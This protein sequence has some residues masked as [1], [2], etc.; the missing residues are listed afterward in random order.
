MP[1]TVTDCGPLTTD[2][3]CADMVGR[4]RQVSGL[5]HVQRAPGMIKVRLADCPMARAQG[6]QR[7]RVRERA[8]ER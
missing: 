7:E 4:R 8:C 6:G 1:A 3:G 5:L 2:E